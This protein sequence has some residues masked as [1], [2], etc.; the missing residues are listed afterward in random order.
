MKEIRGFRLQDEPPG[1]SYEAV[2]RA[3]TSGFLSNIAVKKEKNLYLGTKGRKVMLFPGSGLFNRGGEWIVA[4]ELV[5]TSRLFART[6]AQVQP[7]WIEEFGKHLCRSSYEEPHWEKRRGQ[8]VALERVTLYGLV[9]VNGRRVN[10][11]RIRPKEAREIFI[12]SGLVEAE[13]PGKYGFLEHNRKLIQ[14][15]RD[16]EDRI[17]RRELLVDDEALYAFYDARLPEIADIRSFNR[18]LKDQGGDEVLRMSE[19]DLLRFRR[20]RRRWSSFPALSISRT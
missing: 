8:V 6:A 18:W 19:D 11:G 13:M 9:I 20:N 1:V 12:R 4:A 7:E 10:Y 15:I 2:H 5:Q 17:R 14:R 3:V 16:M